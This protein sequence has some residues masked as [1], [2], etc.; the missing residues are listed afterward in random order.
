MALDCCFADRV[1][2]L[3]RP[4]TVWW[5][6]ALTVLAGVHRT[7]AAESPSPRVLLLDAAVI[8]RDIVAVGEIGTVLRSPDSG[9]SWTSVPPTTKATLTGVSF[10]PGSRR[11]WAVGHDALILATED[12]GKTWSKAWQ[13]ESLDASF[14]DV[15]ALSTDH[16]IAVGAYGLY[17]ETRDAGRTWTARLILEEDMHLNRISR[18]P[19]G[20]LYIAGE[21]GTLLRSTD[22]GGTWKPIDS[23]YDGSFYGILPLGPDT[24]LAYGLRG[25]VFRSVDNGAS[26]APVVLPQPALIATAVRLADGAVVLAGQARAQFISHD[27]GV[28]FA[29]Q[30]VGFEHAIAELLVAPAGTLLAFGEAGA[31][32]LGD[33]APASSPAQAPSPADNAR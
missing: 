32:R 6:C 3:R 18:G 14:L 1:R 21:R 11:G 22:H 28:S 19:T 2:L 29:P 12:G 9:Q 4:G 23:P 25:R 26:W 33:H 15:C 20:A 31:S 24:L 27:E 13:G 10:A 16:V 30:T 7:P 5:V 17:L 8:D